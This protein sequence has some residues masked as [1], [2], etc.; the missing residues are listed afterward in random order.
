MAALRKEAVK[1]NSCIRRTIWQTI[2]ELRHITPKKDISV[3]LDS[4]GMFEKLWQF[5]SYL[6]QRGFKILEVGANENIIESTFP[7]VKE[8]SNRIML[9]AIDKGK[10][11]IQEMTYQDRPCKAITLYDKIYGIFTT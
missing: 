10:P 3:I 2:L 6:V 4:N 7:A 5:S 9:R 11:E 1:E 8:V